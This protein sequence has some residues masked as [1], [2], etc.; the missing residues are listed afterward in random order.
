VSNKPREIA[1]GIMSAEWFVRQNDKVHGPF[2][3][4]TVKQFAA[5]N[6]IGVNTLIARSADGPWH[7]ASKVKG[8]FPDPL[9]PRPT[10]APPP[11]VKA[12]AAMPVAAT[13]AAQAPTPSVPASHQKGYAAQTLEPGEAVAFK[14]RLSDAVLPGPLWILLLSSPF[15]GICLFGLDTTRD[16]PERDRLICKLLGIPGFILL[17]LGLCLLIDTI[18]KVFL[19]EYVV[20]N[21]RVVIRTGFFKRKIEEFLLPS[22]DSVVVEQGLGGQVAKYGTLVLTVGGNKL[23]HK[24]VVN[25]FEFCRIVKEQKPRHSAWS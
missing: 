24:Y 19:N 8:L 25:P 7:P 16:M 15:V 9:A 22:V 11:P 6:R 18:G 1:R 17:I 4:A 2:D 21:K 14:T 3:A 10:T 12:Q 13:Q 5:T 20:T 23:R